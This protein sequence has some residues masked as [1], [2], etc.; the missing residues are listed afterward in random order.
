MERSEAL[1]S[2]DF[3]DDLEPG[4]PKVVDQLYRN[5]SA[6]ATAVMREE[7]FHRARLAS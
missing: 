1:G 3:L 6:L 4:V 5:K 2:G 7:R